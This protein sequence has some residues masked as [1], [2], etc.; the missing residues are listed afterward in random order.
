MRT[1]EPATYEALVAR[2]RKELGEELP[3]VL[4]SLDPFVLE[5]GCGHGHFLTAYA[6][7]HPKTLC[8]GIDISR[9]RVT[10]ANRKKDRASAG[11]LHFILAESD[12]FLASLPKEARLS[13]LF[14]LFPDPW[15][16]RRHGKNRL[17]KAAFLTEAAT[18]AQ[19]G[20]PLYL[21]TDHEPY[22]LESEEIVRSHPDWKISGEQLLP[23]EEPTVFEKRAP[24]HFTLVAV[25]R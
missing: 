10:R 21:R 8:V 24:K 4:N 23:F 2:R 9:D 14:I 20:S 18:F 19:K 16:K 25:R 1:A 7:A 6:L 13:V 3:R 17:I 5:V 12:D 22:F 15:P 11:N